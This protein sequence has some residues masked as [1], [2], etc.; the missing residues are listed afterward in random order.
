MN[1]K[2]FVAKLVKFRGRFK[3]IAE[4]AEV[5]HALVRKYAQGNVPKLKQ[6]NVQKV[7]DWMK[8]KRP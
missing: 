8:G 4:E 7:A 1:T 5:S 2:A 3:E 6:E